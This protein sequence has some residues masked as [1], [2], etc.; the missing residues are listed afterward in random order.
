MT[1]AARDSDELLLAE[2]S[3]P[4]SLDDARQSLEYWTRRRATVPLHRRAARREADQMISRCHE[5]VAAAE[6]RRYGSGL[7]GLARRVLAGDG[8]PWQVIRAGLVATLV[9]L[10]PR[11]LSSSRRAILVVWLAVGVFVLLAI[12]QALV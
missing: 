7:K 3:A 5:R 10:V 8:P 1:V 12:A 4:P 6:R 11:R 9:A 2:L